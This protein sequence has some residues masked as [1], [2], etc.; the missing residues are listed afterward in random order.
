MP[1]SE[2]ID[3]RDSMAACL[4]YEMRRQREARALTQDRLAK[5]LYTTRATIQA[6]ESRR[7]RPDEKFC[8][9]L[10]D[11][12]GTD[13]LFQT[14]WFHGQKEHLKEWLQAFLVHEREASQVKTFQPMSIPGLL[15]TEAYIRAG[16]DRTGEVEELIRA[17][18]ARQEILVGENAPYLWVVVDEAAIRRPVGGTAVMKEQLRHLFEMGK[19]P[20]ITIQVVRESIG[21]YVGM[22]G[23]LLL[24]EK[25]D[26]HAVGYVE[27]QF[28][29]RLIEDPEQA[30]RLAIRFDQ[31]R[32]KA[33]SDV[34][35]MVLVLTVMESMD[36]GPVA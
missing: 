17:R 21:S 4:A 19:S 34:D 6:Y 36:D 8:A 13:V 12:F 7:N 35:S 3:P 22:N 33:L 31:I 24:L 2:P 9:R 30:R 16:D 26:G 11:Y 20:K 29:G 18:L 15:Q 27:A 23:G 25:S 14:L 32:S 10:D 1:P 5:E 28:G